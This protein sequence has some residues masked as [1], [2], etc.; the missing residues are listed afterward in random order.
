[1]ANGERWGVV[2]VERFLFYDHVPVDESLFVRVPAV[3][4][5]QDLKGFHWG[6][7]NPDLP[8]LAK[9]RQKLAL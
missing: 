9:A 7:R 1:M 3:E 4:P 2:L 6:P 8:R 5:K